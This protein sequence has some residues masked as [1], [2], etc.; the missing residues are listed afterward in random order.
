MKKTLLALL[1]FVILSTPLTVTA[2]QS[3]DFTY[4]SDGSAITIDSY[5]GAGGVVTI[6]STIAGLPS[7]LSDIKRS[8]TAPA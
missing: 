6:P 4:T 3:G 2:D 8:G 7:P 1:G 5:T